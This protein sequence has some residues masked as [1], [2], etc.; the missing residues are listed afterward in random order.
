MVQDWAGFAAG[1]GHSNR[2]PPA[3]GLCV[4]GMAA[5][6]DKQY[7]YTLL[8][9][10]NI[11]AVKALEFNPSS[12]TFLLFSVLINTTM[13]QEEEKRFEAFPSSALCCAVFLYSD[14][15]LS[16]S[17]LLLEDIL[18]AGVGHHGSSQ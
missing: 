18:G 12:P 16:V 15:G 9:M 7:L 4:K 10:V 1:S 13:K 8:G 6:L 14:C 2:F 11:C 5:L 3:D 17:F